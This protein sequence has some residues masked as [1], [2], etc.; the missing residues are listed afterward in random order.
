MLTYLHLWWWNRAKCF[1]EVYKLIQFRFVCIISWPVRNNEQCLHINKVANKVK[2]NK[3]RNE[4]KK[5]MTNYSGHNAS[6]CC[7]VTYLPT[8]VFLVFVLTIV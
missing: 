3:Y 8:S 2:C 7:P 4:T 5:M 6:L 1:I